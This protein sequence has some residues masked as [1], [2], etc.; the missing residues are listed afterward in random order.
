MPIYSTNNIGDQT[1]PY[2]ILDNS[3]N[4]IKDIIDG[5]NELSEKIINRKTNYYY[6]TIC[7]K[8]EI[9]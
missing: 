4:F 9:W 6:R 2:E 3:T 7:F 5:K 1:Y 8:N